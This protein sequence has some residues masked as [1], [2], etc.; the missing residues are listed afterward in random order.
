MILYANDSI[1][2]GTWEVTQVSLEKNTDG[3]VD[4]AMYKTIADV[5]DYIRFPQVIEVKESATMVL[6]YFD[7]EEKRTAVY[8]LDGDRLTIIV[9][10]VGYYCRFGIVEGNLVL[11]IENTVASRNAAGQIAYHTEKQVFTLKKQ[12]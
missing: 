3:K 7:S 10:V 4:T 12:P 6:S 9:G 8:T 5:K 11:T 2:H 1:P